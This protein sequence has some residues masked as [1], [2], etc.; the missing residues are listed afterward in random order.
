MEKERE[1]LEC[2]VKATQ[3]LCCRNLVK[4]EKDLQQTQ[5]RL[6]ETQNE[7]AV[8]LEGKHQEMERLQKE[9]DDCKAQP[10]HLAAFIRQRTPDAGAAA[11]T[12]ATRRPEKCSQVQVLP[13]PSNSSQVQVLSLS[14]LPNSSQVQVLPLPSSL[15]SN[16]A[17]SGVSAYEGKVKNRATPVNLPVKLIKSEAILS[18]GVVL[19]SIILNKPLKAS[20]STLV[21]VYRVFTHLL[22]PFPEEITQSDV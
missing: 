4:A 13:L 9:S 6:R 8:L 2:Q 15:A 17:F 10:G 11:R 7:A 19:F 22:K 18:E 3:S 20:E 1:L 12:E 5:S 21:D 14:P 16:L